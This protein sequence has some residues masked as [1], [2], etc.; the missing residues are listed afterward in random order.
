MAYAP[1]DSKSCAIFIKTNHY[2]RFVTH[3]KTFLED[4]NFRYTSLILLI[5]IEERFKDTHD[6][7]N[8]C[9][10]IVDAI[11]NKLVIL[12]T[13]PRLQHLQ[14]QSAY[15]FGT[16]GVK[17]LNVPIFFTWPFLMYSLL[18]TSYH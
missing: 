4:N 16:L 3:T 14:E 7:T 2:K 15:I 9:R 18:I 13:A 17:R 11:P 6:T 10:L 8:L 1:S 5:I 12:P